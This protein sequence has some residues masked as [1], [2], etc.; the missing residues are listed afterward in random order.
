MN[1]FLLSDDDATTD[2]VRKVLFHEGIECPASHVLSID[3]AVPRL[4]RDEPDL[5]VVVLPKDPEG[6]VRALDALSNVPRHERVRALAVGPASDPKVV[7]RALRGLVD[8]YVDEADLEGELLSALARWK[9][10][11]LASQ[12]EDHGRVIVVLAPN[13]GSGSSTLAANVATVLA[14]EHRTAALIDMKLETGDLAALLDLKPAHS[15]ADLCQNLE[16]M[17]RSMFERVFASHGSGVQLLAPPRHLA[18]VGRITPDG[19]RQALRL[20][21]TIFPYVVVDLDHSFRE[22]QLQVLRQADVILLV[23]RLDFAALRNARRTLDYLEQL[24]IAPERVQLVA[25]RYGQP[26]EVPYGKAEEALGLKIAHFIPDDPKT[27]NRANNN[28]VPLVL[29]SPSTKVSRSVSRLAISVNGRHK[30]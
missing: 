8:D 4:I 15:L 9:A 17:D 24:G 3:S 12:G 22:E 13:G 2:R 6:A 23:L 1:V 30:E 18:D 25:N 20:A 26:K 29:D 19:I 27:V 21:R 10:S 16:R 28:G 11:G 7:I 14:K 5:I